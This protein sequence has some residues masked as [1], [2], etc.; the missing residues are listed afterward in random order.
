[1]ESRRIRM[2]KRL[3]KEA[4]LELMEQKP[5]ASISVTDVC[6]SADVNRSTFYVYYR[7]PSDILDEIENE[8]FSRMPELSDIINIDNDTAFIKQNTELFDYI[9]ENGRIF[10]TLLF[11]SDNSGFHRKLI[12]KVLD[13][14]SYIEPIYDDGFDLYRRL[15]AAN[16]AVGM[17]CQWIKDDFPISSG[18]FVK[19]LLK[20]ARRE[21][22]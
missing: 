2:T 10:R 14:Y 8:L 21:K 4:I 6:R 17:M 7:K 5:I 9:R 11:D 18:E 16:G 13:K 12:Q 15:F 3:M 1:M 20:V 22:I 19:L